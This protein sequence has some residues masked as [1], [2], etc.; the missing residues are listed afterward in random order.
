MH[1][2]DMDIS[3]S[4]LGPHLYKGLVSENWSINNTPNGGYLM[5][6]L[7]NA[8]LSRSDK[9]STPIPDRNY[10]SRCSPGDAD[11][12]MEEFSRTT[13]F[14]RYQAGLYQQGKERIRAWGHLQ[15]RR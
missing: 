13:Q 5:A 7:A 15:M 12:Q 8:M 1:L 2:F 11:I 6:L 4:E 9:R 14:N 3:S 10:I